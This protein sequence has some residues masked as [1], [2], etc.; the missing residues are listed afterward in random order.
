MTPDDH[1][2][3]F[4][5]LTPEETATSQPA[6]K[7][8]TAVKVPI[9]PVPDDA[10]ELRFKHPK[11][12]EPSRTWPY[13]DAA[14]RLL[15]YAARFDF[16]A[17]DGTPG[18]DVLPLTFCDLGKGKRGWRSKGIPDPRPL[19]K[20]PELTARHDAL[21]IVTEGEKA[22]D[23]AAERFPEL[24]ATTPMHGAKS[25]HK[26]DWSPLAGRRVAIWSDQDEP[27]AAFGQAVAALATEAG[28]ASIAMVDVPTDWPTGWDLADETPAG[29]TV[30]TLRTM[31]E[32]AAP[33]EPPAP[34]TAK[35]SRKPAP[36]PDDDDLPQRDRL[37]LCATRGELWRDADHAAY[38]TVEVDGH[39][40]SFAVRSIAYRRH[41]LKIYGSRYQ[42]VIAEGDT[43][44]TIPGSPS[45]Q[46]LAD[47]MNSIEAIAG[48]GPEKVPAVRVGE[49]DGCVV[50]DLGTSDWSAVVIGPDGWKVVAHPPVPFI[51]PAGLRPLPVP[52][53][54]GR[55]TELRPFL[56]IGS[57]EDFRLAVAWIVACLKR[58]G[59]FPVMV[60]N[61]EQGAAKSTFCRVL[62]RLIDPNAADLRSPPK[63]ERDALLAAR[64]GWV[65]GYDNLSFIDGDQSDWFCRIATG[66]GFATRAL[67]TNNEEVL[68]DVCRPVLLNGI[69]ALAS[70]PDLAD[71]AVALTL[72][73]MT[74]EARRPE[75][76]F[77]TEF[78]AAAPRILGALFDGVSTALRNRATVKLSRLP[79]M[80]DF[81]LWAAAAFPSFAWLPDQF[82]DAYETNRAQGVAEAVE[83]D[84]VAS[85]VLEV[86]ADR[87]VWN[88]TAT[89]LLSDINLKVA[90]EVSRDKTWPKDGTRL[91]NR[92]RRVAPA[93]RSL[94]IE[95]VL[96]L[97]E[98]RGTE[99]RRVIQIRRVKDDPAPAVEWEETI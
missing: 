5:P 43:K 60:V 72:P 65:L 16:S 1:A 89:D 31:I 76:T 25:P 4:A 77:W 35:P 55:I 45:S 3:M 47:A 28:A 34:T 33:W 91:S 56:N 63:D 98:G 13:H 11:Y 19:Y 73:A 84:P 80:A 2:G 49:H 54:G 27:G 61:G 7:A 74:A 41:L 36:E 57:D 99:R 97:R 67:Y 8:T 95:I 14:G 75:G 50:I 46:A 79:R 59:P 32:A 92:L 94:G 38:A 21:V 82:V 22:A 81:A 58:N 12:G 10:P 71:R 39:L 30:D 17:S 40:E 15:G 85:A 51:R 64:N 66:G 44:H 96:D 18:K 90:L 70:R 48:N 78:D 93:L 87:D 42:Q 88:G 9:L 26:T 29:V 37:I 52:V 20:L 69:P 62:R 68:I 6:G 53:K 86:M 23:A 83:A 24:V